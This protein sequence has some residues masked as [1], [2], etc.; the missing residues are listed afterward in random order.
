MQ[1]FAYTLASSVAEA[2]TDH[3]NAPGA[4]YL[5]GGTTLLDLVK[6]DVLRPPRVIDLGALPH[7]R[8]ER[9][10]DGSLRVG[11]LV[12]NSDL[13]RHPLIRQDY[14]VLAEAILVGASA[15]IRNMATTGGNL[16]QR[17]RCPYFRDNISPCNKRLPGSGCAALHGWNR[18]HALLG[19]SAHC[20]AT[21][22]SDLCVALAV[23]D[24]TVEIHGEEGTRRIPYAAFHRLPDA[25]PHVEN[26][27]NSG[28]VVTAVLLPPPPD[29]ARSW[30]LKARD[31]ESFSFALASTAVLVTQTPSGLFD[32]VRIALGGVA[33]KPW[34]ANQAEELLTGGPATPERLLD[35][36]AAAFREAR[37][38][39]Y[40]AFK[41]PLAQRLLI[42]ALTLVAA[43]QPTV[44]CI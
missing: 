10:S 18:T 2:W 36:A 42:R 29:G 34:R 24:A 20:I 35:A 16:L 8:I 22:P 7:N 31:R 19:G 28:D 1:P 12:R 43:G 6:L 5:G 33:T 14:P 21:H 17:T 27:L 9:Q 37:P 30:Y 32:D 41:I 23:L 11:T 40:N 15:Q 4:A 38:T 44:R 26:T 25:T 3:T 13:A 39:H